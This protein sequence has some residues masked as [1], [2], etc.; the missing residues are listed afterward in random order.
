MSTLK[1][2]SQFNEF[3]KSTHVKICRDHLVERESLSIL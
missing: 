1:I 2:A 3:D